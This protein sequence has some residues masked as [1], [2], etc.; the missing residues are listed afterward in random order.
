MSREGILATLDLCRVKKL[1]M[2][3]AILCHFRILD[4]AGMSGRDDVI[5]HA[6]YYLVRVIS[7][8]TI[9]GCIGVH[10]S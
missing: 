2:D 3:E 6:G 4:G 1:R 10:S 7:F 8:R 9:S 5:Y